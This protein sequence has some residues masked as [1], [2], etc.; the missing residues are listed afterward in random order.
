MAAILL[1]SGCTQQAPPIGGT[2]TGD[3]T[4]SA[5]GAGNYTV[6]ISGYSFS[7]AQLTVKKGSTVTWEN[8][9]P[10]QHSVTSDS[11]SEL[12][13]PLFG[14]GGTY[15]HTFNTA[16]E[17]DYHCSIHAVMKGKIIVE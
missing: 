14:T 2:G 6:Q 15:A 1:L 11:G 16:G 9:D 8:N 4:G 13:S 17:F 3:G 7:P 5:G 12:G 10:T